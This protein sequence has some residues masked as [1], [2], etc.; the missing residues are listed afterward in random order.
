MWPDTLTEAGP[1]LVG[2]VV[3]A[4]V[5]IGAGRKVWVFARRIGHFLDDVSGEPERPGV[6]ARPGLMER[7]AAI[8]DR[9]GHVEHEVQT[10]QGGSL[11]DA[12]RRT[13]VHMAELCR[14][15]DP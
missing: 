11:K 6:P 4:T 10:N 7:V 15:S 14:R 12:V 9:L 3:G 8:E 1:W 2:A 13:E 5:L